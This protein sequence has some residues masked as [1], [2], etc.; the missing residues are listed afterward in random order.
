MISTNM[1]TERKSAVLMAGAVVV[2]AITLGFMLMSKPRAIGSTLSRNREER[3]IKT[4]T[5][6]AEAAWKKSTAAALPRLWSGTPDQVA[7]AA[8]STVSALVRRHN[9]RLVA[10]RP[11]RAAEGFE[12]AQV[13]FLISLEGPFPAVTGFVRD[14]DSQGSRLAVNLVQV[15]SAD[16]TSD[17]VN[18]TVGAVAFLKPVEKKE[19]KSGKGS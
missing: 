2:L 10:F 8:M 12:L 16:P 3:K 11:Q 9:L 13:P 19:V 15:A 14:L 7:P 18:A 4:E 6:Q 17:R 5:A 1:T